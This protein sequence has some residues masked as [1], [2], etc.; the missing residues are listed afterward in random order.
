MTT[1]HR[2]RPDAADLHPA[3]YERLPSGAWLT[4]HPLLDADVGGAAIARL[5][6]RDALHAAELHGGRLPTRAEVIDGIAAARRTGVVLR[7]VAS[8]GQTKGS[9]PR[10]ASAQMTKTSRAMIVR[11]QNG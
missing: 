8:G 6:Y 2:T 9:L 11:D 4:R 7:P 10:A 1:P 3:G 5:T